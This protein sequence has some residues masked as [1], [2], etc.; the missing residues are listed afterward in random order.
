MAMAANETN[1]TIVMFGGTDVNRHSLGD[2]WTFDGVQWTAA[3]PVHAP[4]PRHSARMAFD[5]VNGKMLLFGGSIDTDD[6]KPPGC[7]LQVGLQNDTWLWDGTDW[8]NQLPGQCPRGE[9]FLHDV[10]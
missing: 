2:T 5:P 3:T 4:C 10:R 9:S 7:E 6:P 8:M 1:N